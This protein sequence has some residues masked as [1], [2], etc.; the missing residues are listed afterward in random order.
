MTAHGDTASGSQRPHAPGED[1]ALPRDPEH[2]RAAG[3]RLE[4]DTEGGAEAAA[5]ADRHDRGH[6]GAPEDNPAHNTAPDGRAGGGDDAP[7]G[8][9]ETT[10][11]QLDAD[12]AVE[13]DAL[14]A[15]DPDDSPA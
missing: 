5:Q 6:T 12:T 11:E 9:D 10:E 8:G 14:K 3:A 2:A 4:A 13:Q 1:P 7:L 15:L